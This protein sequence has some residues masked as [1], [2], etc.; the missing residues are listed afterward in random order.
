MHISGRKRKGIRE[1]IESCRDRARRARCALNEN[2]PLSLETLMHSE[3]LSDIEFGLPTPGDQ[4]CRVWDVQMREADELVRTCAATQTKWN[5]R[6]HG[7]IS[8]P[9]GKFQTAAT[10]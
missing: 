7:S 9:P 2:P 10:K 6:I 5:A 8:A 4:I 1:S 3:T